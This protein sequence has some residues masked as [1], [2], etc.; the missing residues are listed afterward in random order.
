M[1]LRHWMKAGTVL[2]AALLAGCASAPTAERYMPPP[3]GATWTLQHTDSGSFGA[4]VSNVG[5]RMTTRMLNGRELLAFE[6]TQQTVVAQPNGDWVGFMAND[7]RMLVSFEPVNGWDWPLQVGNSWT[8]QAG[9][10]FHAQNRVVPVQSK[11]VVEAQEQVT[12]P[13]GTFW[14][15]RIRTTDSLGTDN[16][17]WFA[18][19]LGIF[20]K[21]SVT[22]SAQH[23]QGAGKRESELMVFKRP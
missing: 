18:P 6:S 12:V 20:A 9:V 8:R 2:L 1:D 17:V 14:S 4:G 21:Q 19:E 23:P 10:R 13:A 11:A 5:S 15:Y 7:G 3:Q 22:R 16:L